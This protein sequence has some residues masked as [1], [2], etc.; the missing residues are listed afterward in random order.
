MA[1]DKH[2][3]KEMALLEI[4]RNSKEAVNQTYIAFHLKIFIIVFE[5]L[6]I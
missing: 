5:C 4:L 1:S 3:A 6:D 2:H